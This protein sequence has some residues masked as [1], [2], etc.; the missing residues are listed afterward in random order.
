MEALTLSSPMVIEVVGLPGAGKS[1]F[2]NQFAS[3]FGAALVSR[4]KIRWTLF[5]KHTYSDS[6]NAM[7]DQVAELL[8]T[9]LFRTKKT[10]ILDGGCNTLAERREISNRARRNGYRVLTIVVQTDE[11]TSRRRATKRNEKKQGDRYKQSLTS[12]QFDSFKKAYAEPPTDQ[13]DVVVIS[14][15]HTYNAQAK[16]VLRKMIE[17]SGQTMSSVEPATTLTPRPALNIKPRG[18]FVR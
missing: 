13:A 14:G 6:E 5:A 12:E 15:K 8:I 2:A 18:P 17:T 1:F 10:F 9:E 11:P 16:V 7:V 4:D 3:T